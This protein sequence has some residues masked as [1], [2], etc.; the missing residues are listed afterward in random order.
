MDAKIEINK[1]ILDKLNKLAEK[2]KRPLKDLINMILLD[3]VMEHK[4]EL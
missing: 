2:E 3:Y 1:H 4:G